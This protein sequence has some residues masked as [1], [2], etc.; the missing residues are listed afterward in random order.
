MR[1]VGRLTGVLGRQND[2]EDSLTW[3][4][5]T[6]EPERALADSF[7]RGLLKAAVATLE[8]LEHD[9]DLSELLPYVLDPLAPG[10]RSSVIRDSSTAT[11]RDAK[12]LV[13]NYY[14]P[15]D[16]ADFMVR[17]VLRDTGRSPVNSAWL[18]PACGTGVFLRAILRQ[19]HAAD[20]ASDGLEQVKRCLFGVDISALA[21]QAAT[22]VL[23]HDC[24]A[25]IAGASLSPIKAWHLI[26]LNLAAVDTTRMFR[27]GGTEERDARE[28]LREMIC[29]DSLP[30]PA[31]SLADLADGSDNPLRPLWGIPVGRIFPEQSA[32]FDLL[33]GNP[34]YAPIGRR[35]DVWRYSDRYG[36]L[37]HPVKASDSLYPLFVEM[38]W[39]LTKPE[40]SAAALV[41]P[42]S[43]AYSG[44]A[45]LVSCRKAIM[46][47]GGQWR[48][49][50]FD[51]EPHALFGEEV[52]TRN[53]IAVRCLH[54]ASERSEFGVATGPVLKWRSRSRGRLFDSIRFTQIGCHSIVQGIPKLSG[55]MQTE[56]LATLIARRETLSASCVT[57]RSTPSLEAFHPSALPTVY[58]GGTA[59][60]F[61]NVFRTHMH[62]LSTSHPLASSPLMSLSARNERTAS[63]VFAILSS[64]LVF[65]W[66]KVHGDGF[67]VPRSFVQSIPFSPLH[68]S[69]RHAARL[70]V[71]GD[72]LWNAISSRP[73]VHINGGRASVGYS[74]IAEQ[75]MRRE[76]DEILIETA[77]LPQSFESELQRFVETSVEADPTR[78]LPTPIV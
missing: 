33:V 62:Y 6:A 52:K 78:S 42:L 22:F 1:L 70:A 2:F 29:S 14:T 24:H 18:D 10:S 66:W 46:S 31:A 4:F 36:S 71:V 47:V 54:S 55:S 3:F 72:T 67:H 37:S 7:D 26:R 64:K 63:Q 21:I 8:E 69:D 60:N 61:L 11:A 23:L 41:L 40:Q 13:G 77:V 44:D 58:V 56:V 38:M 30:P 16:V 39:A 50:F 49:A 45:Q 32:G 51:R 43:I 53:C 20:P 25:S 76:I 68:L 15:S 65:W 9:E 17:E 27:D 28:Q 19:V 57:I 74:P 5:E 73:T 59:Y 34:P 12:R 35:P 48:F 75:Q